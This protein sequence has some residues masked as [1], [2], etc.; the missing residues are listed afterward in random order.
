[1]SKKLTKKSMLL[2]GRNSVLERLR[3]NPKSIKK[4]LLQDNL[5]LAQIEKLIKKNNIPTERLSA[6][7]LSQLKHAKDLQGVIAQV[8][9]FAYTPFRDLL[10]RPERPSLIFLDR[11]NDPQNLGVI[12]RTASCFGGFAVI[13]PAYQACEVTEAVL[14]VASGGEN[15]IPVSMVS[16]LSNAIIR[17]KQNNYWIVGAE[18]ADTAESINKTSLP[19]P[20]GLVLGSEGEGIRHGLKKHLDVKVHI[21]MQGAKLSF[22]V[23]MAC[24]IFCHE[25]TKQRAQNK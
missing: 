15:Y 21:P 6:K 11:I 16:N 5:E 1:M 9:N 24:T 23:S 3:A 17:A 25:I 22:N 14:H 7:R 8:E 19:F 2:Y 4:V 18:A 10:E 20:L 12:I 13:I